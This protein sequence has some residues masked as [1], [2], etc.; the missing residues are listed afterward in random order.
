MWL[1]NLC[2]GFEILRVR[3]DILAHAKHVAR[4]IHTLF[5]AKM[6]Q[7]PHEYCAIDLKD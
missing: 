3:T 6:P 4:N 2:W 7:N 5:Q 1:R